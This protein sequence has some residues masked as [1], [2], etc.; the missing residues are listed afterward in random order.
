[1]RR[2]SSAWRCGCGWAIEAAIKR[3]Q[4]GGKSGGPY[5]AE[6]HIS[7][8][9]ALLR[10]DKVGQLQQLFFVDGHSLPKRIGHMAALFSCD[11]PGTTQ[12]RLAFLQ[13]LTGV[14]SHK[15]AS[16]ILPYAT[17]LNTS[18]ELLQ[19]KR[20]ALVAAMGERA[21]HTIL[22][23]RPD[24]L[25]TVEERAALNLAA[26]QQLFG[27][28]QESTAGILCGNTRLLKLDMQSSA[29]EAKLSA[30]VAFWQQVYGLTAD[31]AAVRCTVMLHQSL[32]TV[33][34]RVAYYQQQLTEQPLPPC[35]G[36]AR[37]DGTFCE[38]FKLNPRAFAAFKARWLA[39][40]EGR[41]VSA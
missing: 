1:M 19:R 38:R 20:D 5:I 15:L 14:P 23:M 8:A 28:S 12:P 4:R 34:P 39:S 40:A 18:E 35:T 41:A 26:L 27:V 2:C 11:I 21:A 36:F 13:A 30:R 29:T 6:Q 24:V 9:V 37:G 7:E 10:R 16:R 33:A 32:R 17:L 25:E 3:E 31:V 22:C